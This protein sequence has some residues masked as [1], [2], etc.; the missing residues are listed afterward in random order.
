MKKA[1]LLLI[2]AIQILFV[3]PSFS[4]E[5]FIRDVIAKP[6]KMVSP[7][8]KS[9]DAQN[10][11]QQERQII[12]DYLKQINS[13][14]S[15]G[16]LSVITDLID[17]Q[18]FKFDIIYK[19]V[20]V[21]ENTLTLHYWSD[22]TLMITGANL[23]SNDIEITP[24]LTKEQAIEK[25]KL[26]DNRIN[27]STI[28]SNQLVIYKDLETEPYLCYKI[29]VAL[30]I[31]ESYHYYVSALN[32]DI[33]KKLSLTRNSTPEIG[34]AYLQNWGTQTIY[35]SFKSINNKYILFDQGADIQTY[36]MRGQNY[37]INAEN[38]TDLDNNWTLTEFPETRTY[39]MNAA[40]VCHWGA[41]KTYDFFFNTFNLASYNGNNKKINLYVNCG[42]EENGD[43][44]FW[45][46]TYDIIKIGS[47]SND[48]NKH[49]YGTVDIVAH[50][51]GHAVTDY[52]GKANLK[53]E[54]ESGAI[55]EGLSDIW[56]ACVENYIGGQ[57]NYEIWNI[58]D[59]RGYSI[60]CMSNPKSMGDPN[61][62][63]KTYWVNTTDTSDDNDHGGV[64]SNSGIL[65][66]WFYL[67]TMGGSGTNDN[68][69]QYE[70]NGLGFSVSQRI[71]YQTLVAHLEKNSN[72]AQFRISTLDAT[73][74]LYGETSNAY[75]Q[76]MNAWHAVGV[77]Q[78]YMGAGIAGD[79]G[80]C[81]GGE[82]SIYKHPAV[83][84]TWSVDNFTNTFNQQRPKLT[85]ISGQNTESIIVE[86]T[87]TGLAHQDG[88]IY[89]YNGPV[90][91]TATLTYGNTVITKQKSLFSN[92]P[93][94][95]I[96]YTTTQGSGLPV[97]KTYKFYV[98]GVATNHLRW[99][100]EAN[101]NT[102]T[103]IAQ[104][105]IEISLPT[106]RTYDVV[107]SVSDH[108]NCFSSNYKT[109]TLNG[110]TIVVPV[111]SHENPVTTNSIFYLKKATDETDINAVYNI[112]IWNE[113]GLIRSEKYDDAP[114]FMVSTDS[115]I[116]GM[117]FIR[118]YRNGELL[119][120]QKLI[121]K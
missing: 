40:L 47:G 96:Q 12:D 49:H 72:F 56:A 69:E 24:S 22:S 35:T 36:N 113:Y 86:R 17:K 110:V 4:Q 95:E 7:N 39:S 20:I 101:G 27:D 76:V 46:P 67:L 3:L 81:D 98:N 99:S 92:N 121:V 30:S 15:T 21:D 120:T 105:F 34:T 19:N 52:K 108:G 85:I 51:F 10:D 16:E 80:V 38:W 89:Y 11:Y 26:S 18:H 53:Y 28:L 71:V 112:E 8:A 50:E 106:M 14:F 97:N 118:I 115:L 64:H 116:P 94:P 13:N 55:D 62:Y 9:G 41:R 25:L 103:A 54:G 45:D 66:Y 88:T 77:G 93:L 58:G 33:I 32:G 117:Y 44:A 43:N 104:D 114:E 68:Q 59:H 79:F 70:V 82:Y 1:N 84:I 102:Y 78:P 73:A 6:S 111:L 48:L 100:I 2:L 65:N 109:K 75:K 29:R 42:G 23:F 63:G 91:L 83:S 61:T 57:T 119:D 90:Q 107:V 5:L 31:V 87:P 74:Q 37:L 60:R